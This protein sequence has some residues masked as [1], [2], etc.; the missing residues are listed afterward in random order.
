MV[1][2]GARLTML[3]LAATTLAPAQRV[4]SAK[5][6][7]VYFVQGRA[8]V[9]GGGPLTSGN[10]LRQLRAGETLFT[11]RGRAEVLLNPGTVLRLGD[12]SRLR[13]DDVRIT[14]ACV[15]I[16]SGSAVVTVNYLP[17]PDRVELNLGGSVVILSRAG[18]Y[19]FD[20]NGSQT[21]LRVYN[22]RAEVHRGTASA[23]L[24]VKHGRAVDLEDLQIAR[25]DTKQTDSLERWAELRSRTPGP[26]GL[27]PVPPRIG[28]SAG[29]PQSQQPG[30]F[31]TSEISPGVDFSGSPVYSNQNGPGPNGPGR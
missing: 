24:I 10:V 5:S 17:K 1:L 7:L 27:R 30:G 26:G 11:E 14:D 31:Q 6:G 28:R 20:T 25:F 16:L 2:R 22:G 8:F 13:M 21:R 3:V 23:A 29:A 12:R 19:R 9:E 18:V 4:I 15:S